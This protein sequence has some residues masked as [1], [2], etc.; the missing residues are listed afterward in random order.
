[1]IDS[2]V[3]RTLGH[4]QLQPT[5]H[6]II[7]NPLESWFSELFFFS[8]S[9]AFHF[10]D[11]TNVYMEEHFFAWH[12]SA[13]VAAGICNAQGASIDVFGYH[14]KVERL[15]ALTALNCSV[16]VGIVVFNHNS[17]AAIGNNSGKETGCRLAWTGAWRA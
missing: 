5:R 4:G 2:G 11:V 10:N 7:P 9:K 16:K 17:L 3:R 12:R 13:I 15:K 6:F 14:H 1:M 8:Q